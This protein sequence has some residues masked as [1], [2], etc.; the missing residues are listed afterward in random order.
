VSD[1]LYSARN[2]YGPSDRVL[3][4]ERQDLEDIDIIGFVVQVREKRD[5]TNPYVF[6]DLIPFNKAVHKII[7]CIAS[8]GVCDLN[9]LV[10]NST[11]NSVNGVCCSIILDIARA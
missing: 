7:I 5:T 9:L 4:H 3:P 11:S 6:R 1:S 2:V 10:T 8:S